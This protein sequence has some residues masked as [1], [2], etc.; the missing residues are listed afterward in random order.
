MTKEPPLFTWKL[1]DHPELLKQVCETHGIDE[2]EFRERLES[3]EKETAELD[4][5][6]DAIKSG[7]HD[8]DQRTPNR[9]SKR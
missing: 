5:K 4:K 9:V 8:N 6:I 2:Q 1:L 3:F 7:K